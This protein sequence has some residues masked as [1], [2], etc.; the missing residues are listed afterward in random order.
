METFFLSGN[1]L[2]KNNQYELAILEYE[3]ALEVSENLFDKLPISNEKLDILIRLYLNLGFCHGKLR[4]YHLSIEAYNSII[5]K[6]E[7]ERDDCMQ[8]DKNTL[9]LVI[10]ALLRRAIDFEKIEE[11]VRAKNDIDLIYELNPSTKFSEPNLQS[12]YNRLLKIIKKDS[13]IAAEEGKPNWISNAGQTLRLIQLSEVPL[14]ASIDQFIN[15]RIGIGN[16]LGL[17]N[18]SLVLKDETDQNKKYLGKLKCEVIQAI[19]Y[20]IPILIQ[21]HESED[22]SM[23]SSLDIPESGKVN[24]TFRLLV[25]FFTFKSLNFFIC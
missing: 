1:N 16:E 12:Q 24:F 13:Q 6:F 8:L 2:T 14:N 10:K 25:I 11:Y 21:L 5:R 3:K 22:P 17:F 15:M 19:D 4:N 18:R 20:S 7:Y 9:K 23:N